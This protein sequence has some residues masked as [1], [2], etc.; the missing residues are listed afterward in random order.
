LEFT[1]PCK[2]ETYLQEII[3]SRARNVQMFAT[4]R[5]IQDSQDCREFFGSDSSKSTKFDS[6]VAH[7]ILFLFLVGAKIGISRDRLIGEIQYGRHRG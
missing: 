7:T 4:G 6:D 2:N 5:T 3:K 1:E